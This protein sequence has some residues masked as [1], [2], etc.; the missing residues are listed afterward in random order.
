MMAVPALPLRDARPHG[1]VVTGY[2]TPQKT[3]TG[4]ES[5]VPEILKR[6]PENTE[7]QRE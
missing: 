3:A 1:G 5:P 4:P 6:R 7:D 2:N